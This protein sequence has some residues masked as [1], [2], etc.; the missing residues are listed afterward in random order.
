MIDFNTAHCL[1]NTLWRILEERGT[2]EQKFLLNFESFSDFRLIE[3]ESEM[4]L[5]FELLAEYK[6]LRLLDAMHS[7]LRR[8]SA[9]DTIRVLSRFFCQTNRLIKTQFLPSNQANRGERE[10]VMTLQ[11]ESESQ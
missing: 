11:I 8:R 3:Q 9:H 5:N 2:T 6:F 4:Q 10:R 7:A 1:T